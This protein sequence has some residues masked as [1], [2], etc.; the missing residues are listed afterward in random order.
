MR[1]R[2]RYYH[3]LKMKKTALCKMRGQPGE[4]CLLS[5]PC[6]P[7]CRAFIVAVLIIAVLGIVSMV[8]L[9]AVP[10][11]VIVAI[12]A[13]SCCVVVAIITIPP[14]IHPMSSDS[15]GWR[16]VVYCWPCCHHL[17]WLVAML[18]VLGVLVLVGSGII[19]VVDCTH[20]RS[21]LRAEACRHG[22]GV[23]GCLV[24]GR[25]CQ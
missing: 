2:G 17:S 6:H 12:L 13:V 3:K 7:G 23:L 18:R 1:A 15:W 20:S 14:A 5:C 19:I 25:H 9:V 21:T 24:S 8:L 11:L 10:F 22:V 4:S 16:W